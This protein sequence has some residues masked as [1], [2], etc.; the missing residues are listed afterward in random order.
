MSGY[1]VG[2]KIPSSGGRYAV[3]WVCPAGPKVTFW[4]GFTE[5]SMNAD[6]AVEVGA[7]LMAA[8][9]EAVGMVDD[10]DVGRRLDI[11]QEDQT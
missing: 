7:L 4:D 2:E 8:G 10:P 11:T 9:Q 1:R 5:R 6:I 3:P